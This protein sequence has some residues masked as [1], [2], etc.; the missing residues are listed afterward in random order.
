[1]LVDVA[2]VP[3]T[4]K[5]GSFRGICVGGP[6]HVGGYP[7]ELLRFV[8]RYR[9]RLELVPSAFFS[10]G[11]AVASRTTDGR[12]ETLVCVDR[13][14]AKSGWSPSRVELVA[15]A[16]LYTKY[17]FFVRWMMRRIA[18]KAGGDTDVS[19][20]YE[21]TDWLAVERFAAEFAEAVEGSRLLENPRPTFATA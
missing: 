5:L 16:M 9:A 21:Y 8:K 17:N 19:R 18:E 13:F 4:L 1:M 11:L 20:D 15:G 3:R 6:I 7:S 12:A 10:V 2:H 14:V